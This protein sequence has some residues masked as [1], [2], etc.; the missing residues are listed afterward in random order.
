MANVRAAPHNSHPFCFIK[1]LS[2]DICKWNFTFKRCIL[3]S[4]AHPEIFICISLPICI[5][6]DMF[7]VIW[8]PTLWPPC[9]I[10]G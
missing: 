10:T 4:F 3:T 7:L 2:R 5:F 1:Y 8:F 9:Q 6:L